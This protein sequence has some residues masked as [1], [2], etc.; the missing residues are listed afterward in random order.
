MK[1]KLLLLSLLPFAFC[2]LPCKAQ[3]PQGFNYQAIARDGTGNPITGATMQVKID[4][5]SDTIANTIVYGELFNPVKT[6]AF[7]LFN[8]VVGT[9]VKQS[10]SAA[11][12][13]VIDWTKTPL[14]LRTSIYYPSSWKVMGTSKLQSVPY[15]MVAA[16]LEGT[17]PYVGVAGNTTTM[18]SALFVVRN[19]TGQIVFAVYNEG[20]R[21]YV[22][23][24]LAKGSTKG[25]FAIGGFGTSKGSS[26]PLLVV[27]P[28]SIRAYVDN[29]PTKA[30]KGGFAIGGFD[31]S[32]SP[33]QD[34]LDIS[35]DS[36]RMYINDNLTKGSTKGGF[37]IGGFSTS[38]GGSSN[39]FNVATDT[40]G[41]VNPAVN[42]ILWYPLKNAF[43]TGNILIESKDSVGVNS[44]SS[45]YLS[46]AKGS[47]SQALGYQAVA[48]GSYSTAIGKNA[49]ANYSNS[50]AFG[51]GPIASN[52]NSYAFGKSANAIGLSS[53]AFGESVIAGT[54]TSNNCY[55]FGRKSQATGYGSYAFGDSAFAVG[56]ESYAFGSYGKEG[57]FGWGSNTMAQGDY[58]FAA[59]QGAVSTASNSVS[60]GFCTQASGNMSIAMGFASKAGPNHSAIA[61]GEYSTSTGY[62][63]VALGSWNLATGMNSVAL[64][65]STYSQANFSTAIGTYNCGLINSL[66]EI[67]NGYKVGSTIYRSN[68]LT[69]LNSGNVGVITTTPSE[70][71]QVGIEYFGPIYRKAI[72]LGSGGYS[73]PAAYQTNSNGDKLILYNAD[74][75]DA[76]IGIGTQADMWFKSS[77]SAT[78]TGRFV[79]YVGSTPTE[80]MRIDGTGYV[81]IGT[82]SPGYQLEIRSTSAN[83][84]AL[85][86][87]ND[88]YAT[89]FAFGRSA[90][91]GN[92]AIAASAG[93]YA[94]NAAGGDVIL[95]NMT[96]TRKL[97]LTTGSGTSTMYLANGYLY[98]GNGTVAY[99]DGNTWHNASDKNLKDNFEEADGASVLEKIS[100]LPILTWNYKSDTK[101]IR[102]I[103]PTSQDF[104]AAF[105][106]GNDTI[107][108]STIDPAGISLAAIKQLNKQNKLMREEI[109]STIKEN[110]QLRSELDEL[111]SLVN[112]LVT[113]QSGQGNK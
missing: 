79:W 73:E 4:I 48:R 78:N 74:N 40:V 84:F 22:D 21:I 43:L 80:C 27:D 111:K 53:Y 36:I 9:G 89:S 76:R 17:L 14:F 52:V 31:K 72:K 70:L 92:L 97:I 71:L 110:Q 96:P 20:V 66:F 44:F 88:S 77:G 7:G 100:E 10:G 104:Y 60:I 6:N 64:G 95:R 82:S 113:N 25:G 41:I 12:F 55:A 33:I 8:I 45:G 105:G 34:L 93:Q 2:L 29:N 24:G 42:R 61:M 62:G 37:A 67:G 5:L 94:T 15:S 109:E 87:G 59:G 18:D 75:Y 83:G 28:D 112:N 102:H 90:L 47:Y 32:K 39:F 81:G 13:N 56:R 103:G 35:H 46:R 106:L 107:S 99:C 26:Q 85:T 3:V 23:D 68:V 50:F 86:S 30:T 63:S 16:N 108:I 11:S 58:S 1:P 54:D 49:I 69:V 98:M 101:N 51:D 65:Y 91:E 19:N 57:V 38:K